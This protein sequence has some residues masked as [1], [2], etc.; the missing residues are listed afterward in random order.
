MTF[1]MRCLGGLVLGVDLQDSRTSDD[2]LVI[3]FCRRLGE[4]D[5]DLA[6]GA[7]GDGVNFI[8]LVP[9]RD[10]DL[11]RELHQPGEE[12]GVDGRVGCDTEFLLGGSEC[13]SEGH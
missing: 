6:N 11:D 3:E 8:I 10:A 4:D 9:S 12:D 1:R 2:V 7:S 13:A 5:V